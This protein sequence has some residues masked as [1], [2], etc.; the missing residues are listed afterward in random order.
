MSEVPKPML[1]IEVPKPFPYTSNKTVPW[2]YRCNYANETIATDFTG[3]RGITRS[4][5]I[6]MPAII[7]KVAPE[8][9]S[10]PTE[11]EQLSQEKKN[12]STSEKE[13]QP[14]VGKEACEFLKF[15]KHIEYNVVE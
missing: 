10:T 6:Y 8:K 7:D 13:N 1:V 12:G 3:M 2:D 14:I 11:L 4:G 15:I 5:R 9:P